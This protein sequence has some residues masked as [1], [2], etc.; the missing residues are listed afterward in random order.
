MY[1]SEQAL[2][3]SVARPYTGGSTVVIDKGYV[4]E[5]CPDHPKANFWG[6]VGQHRLVYERHHGV[7]LQPRVDIHHDNRN[8]ADNRIENLIA[9]TRSEHMAIHRAETRAMKFLPLDSEMIRAALQETHSLKTAAVLIGCS[10]ETIRN[11]FPELVEPYKRRSPNKLNDTELLET[12]RR[13]AADPNIGYRETATMCGAAWTTVRQICRTNGIEWV[14]KPKI[15][16]GG[17]PRGGPNRVPARRSDDPG[18][19]E[20]I[21]RCAADPDISNKQALDICGTSTVTM[22]KICKENGI[23]W[24]RH[25][26]GP[27]YL[28]KNRRMNANLLV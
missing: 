19:I 27:A 7:Y 13:C 11:R 16:K 9:C 22:R 8:K 10:T 6:Y 28:W 24:N 26:V 17:K 21:R 12:V 20:D 2:S 23:E 4:M 5:L 1:L 25:P 3:P 14:A 15:P 18:L